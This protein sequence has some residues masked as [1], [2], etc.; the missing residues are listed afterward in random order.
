MKSKKRAP[1]PPAVQKP[2]QKQD[3][4]AAGPE[5]RCAFDE[6]VGIEKLVPN[7]RNPNQHPP[8][9]IAL[10][11][12]VVASSGW[13][14]AIVVSN[15]SG[16]VVV[17]HGRLEAARALGLSTVPV[18]YQDFESEAAEYAHMV[19]DNRLAE[20]A[21]MDEAGLR[22][23]LGELKAADFAMDLT[24]FDASALEGLFTIPPEPEP[25]VEFPESDENLAT[26][27][28]C[29]KCS[30]CWSGKAS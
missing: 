10:L 8:Q 27:F 9:Q 20:L 7:P 1:V 23:L 30:Y 29:P 17:G 22:E 16:F 14:A 28:K 13:R 3:S 12:R 24:G 26:E 6:M 5:V 4:E 15:R 19:A 2:Q 25:P 11:A 18:D 21:E